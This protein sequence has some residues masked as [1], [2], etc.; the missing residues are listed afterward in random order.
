MRFRK[1]RIAWSVGWGLLTLLLCVLWATSH[2][3]PI[4]SDVFA[5]PEYRYHVYSLDG[6][7]FFT[8]EGR[9]FRGRE[10]TFYYPESYFAERVTHSGL[11]V[12]RDSNGSIHFLSFS[13]WLLCIA[14]LAVTAVPWLRLRFSLRTLLIATTAVAVLLG[15][16]VLAVRK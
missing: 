8:R 2:W 16:V 15:L 14:S 11:K 3:R 5:T 6:T 4:D 13:Y 10:L 7:V 9:I 12:G 1:L